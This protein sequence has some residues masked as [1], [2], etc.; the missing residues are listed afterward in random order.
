MS[1]SDE[2][3]GW[4]AIG[5]YIS[6]DEKTARKYFKEYGLPVRKIGGRYRASKSELDTWMHARRQGAPK[7][8]PPPAQVDGAGQ[9]KQVAFPARLL[10]L[11]L[12]SLAVLIVLLVGVE[13]LIVRARPGPLEQAV[14][15]QGEFVALDE[16]ERVVWRHSMPDFDPEAIQ[17]ATT[18]LVRDVTGDGQAEVFFNYHPVPSRE[19]AGRLLCFSATGVVRWTF[20]YAAELTIGTRHFTPLYMGHHLRWVEVGGKSLVLIVLRHSTWFPARVVL[21]EPTLGH[22]RAEYWHPGFIEAVTLFDID[23]DGVDELFLGG[24]NNPGPGPGH[25]SLAVL[26][27]PFAEPTTNLPNFFGGGNARER[28]YILFPHIDFLEAQRHMAVVN[29]LTTT[30]SRLRVKVRALDRAELIYDLTRDLTVRNVWPSDTTLQ[31]H[32]A[33]YRAQGLPHVYSEAERDRWQT[34]LSFPTAPDGNSQAV[35]DAFAQAHSVGTLD[36]VR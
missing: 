1:D 28:A 18:P 5:G 33:Y 17:P 20:S 4:F 31:N 29:E 36:E 3:H 22:V 35:R 24:V 14:I 26:D 2:L 32:D 16:R 30:G 10:P 23:Q 6:V 19:E 13:N 21:L 8:V 15:R 34:V 11:T 9:K 25:P 7:R 27:L 12:L